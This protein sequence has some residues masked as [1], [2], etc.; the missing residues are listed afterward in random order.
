MEIGCNLDRIENCH[1]NKDKYDINSEGFVS[2]ISSSSIMCLTEHFKSKFGVIFD[3]DGVIV[4][5]NPMHA[6][7]LRRF[8]ER[9][10][11]I[12]TDE[13]LKTRV[14]GRANKD[15]L[16]EIFGDLLTPEQYKL[17]ADEKE[18]LFRE[19]YSPIIQPLPGL[20]KFLDQLHSNQIPMALASSAPPQNVQFTLEKTGTKKYFPIILDETSIRQGKPD[21][22]IYLKTADQLAL[23]PDR[24]VVFEDSL[25]GIEAAR[26]AGC[27]VVGVATTHPR[28][29]L[30]GTDM[31]I[32][33]FEGLDWHVV[34]ECFKRK[35]Q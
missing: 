15:W 20:I 19:L 9:H 2:A 8:C 6:I 4:D 32:D 13:E 1:Q 11:H 7:A 27:R 25:S 28:S 26:R 33:S 3:M 31:V 12:L 18:A 14:Y 35:R 22:E 30:V 24:C 5:S 21:P 34:A 29:E 16:P 23:P 10:G 17:L